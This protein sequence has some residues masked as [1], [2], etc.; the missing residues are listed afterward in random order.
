MICN[1]E[2]S[3]VFVLDLT[4]VNNDIYSADHKLATEINDILLGKD[5]N[6]D[7]I[8]RSRFVDSKSKE[9]YEMGIEY[10]KTVSKLSEEKRTNGGILI[11]GDVASNAI[12]FYSD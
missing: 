12:K 5:A 4:R 6:A 7:D 11:D 9:A 10:W 1:S 8:F 3:Y 2:N